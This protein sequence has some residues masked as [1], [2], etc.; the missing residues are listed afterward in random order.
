MVSYVTRLLHILM[1]YDFWGE[2]R[3][4]HRGRACA[5]GLLKFPYGGSC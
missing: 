4:V 5:E 3:L 1:D 2:E